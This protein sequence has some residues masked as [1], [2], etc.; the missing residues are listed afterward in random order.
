MPVARKKKSRKA[1]PARKALIVVSGN[2]VFVG[3]ATR[4]TKRGLAAKVKNYK[5]SKDPAA[6]KASVAFVVERASGLVRLCAAPYG[7]GK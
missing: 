1:A 7:V 2:A 6:V 5:V 4:L 3:Y